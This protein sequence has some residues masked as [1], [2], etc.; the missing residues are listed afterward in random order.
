LP[1]IFGRRSYEIESRDYY[2]IEMAGDVGEAVDPRRIL[3]SLWRWKWWIAACTVIGVLVGTVGSRFV[4][5]E[6]EISSSAWLE[7]RHD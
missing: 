3:A 6:Y 1:T 2:P 7:Q 5:P 4:K